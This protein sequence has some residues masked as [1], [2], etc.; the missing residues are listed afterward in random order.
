MGHQAWGTN[1]SNYALSAPK[2][3]FSWNLMRICIV[4]QIRLDGINEKVELKVLRE[5]RAKSIC[6]QFQIEKKKTAR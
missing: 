5:E 4:E 2:C 1:R 6:D 3:L